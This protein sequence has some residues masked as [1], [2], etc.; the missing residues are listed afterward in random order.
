MSR[1]MNDLVQHAGGIPGV[2]DLAREYP[3]DTAE[4]LIIA[5]HLLDAAR[6]FRE[7]AILRVKGW[8][9]PKG[10]TFFRKQ[11]RKADESSDK[12]AAFFYRLMKNIGQGLHKECQAFTVL[13][14]PGK[15]TSILDWCMAPGGFLAV[16]LRLNPDAR[17]LA[18]SLPEEQGG[19]RVLLPDS[20][21]VE[22]RLLDITLLA[23]DMGCETFSRDHPDARKF[24]SRQLEPDRRF[25][26]VICDGATLRNHIRDPNKKDC[27]ARRLTTTQ[28]ALGLEHVEPG[29][30][31]VILLHKV[32]A[33]DTVTILNRFNKFSNIKLYKPKPGHETRSSFYLIATNIQTQHPEALAAIEKWKA[34]WRVLTFEPEECHANVIRKGELGPEQLLD[35]FGSDLVDLGRCVWK[36]QAE[37]LAKAPFTQSKKGPT[38]C[39]KPA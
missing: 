28:L 7:L 14:T 29:G 6:E 30:T 5:T 23:E 11:R 26:L 16:A 34:I 13:A 19:H 4:S 20:I 24:Q 1:V 3:R 31:M 10:D 12:T 22:R 18:F 27:E 35:E 21:N 9:N 15:I 38:R 17:A 8:N 32:E 25:G 33:W 37:A 2:H 36:V 39:S